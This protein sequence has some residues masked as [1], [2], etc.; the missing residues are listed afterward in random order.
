MRKLAEKSRAS[1]GEIGADIS[2][3]AD[4]I[5]RVAQEIESQARDVSLLSG[6]L[7][8]IE[9]FSTLSAETAG[10][11]RAV[12]DTLKHLTDTQLTQA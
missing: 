1:A 11:T 10:H 2:S 7:A 4:E 6:M 3:L 5:A 12:A 8:D 9:S